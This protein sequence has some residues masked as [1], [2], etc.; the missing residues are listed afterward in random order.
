M[1]KNDTYPAVWVSAMWFPPLIF[2]GVSV[3]SVDPTVAPSRLPLHMSLI[4]SRPDRCWGL[5]TLNREG[6]VG[7]TIQEKTKYMQSEIISFR[8]KESDL[9]YLDWQGIK[10]DWVL[11]TFYIGCIFIFIFKTAKKL[12]NKEKYGL[13]KSFDKN[14]DLLKG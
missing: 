11:I 10:L 7:I 14:P 4:S 9:L 3:I 2:P 5:V 12:H 6:G 13:L 1:T 8:L